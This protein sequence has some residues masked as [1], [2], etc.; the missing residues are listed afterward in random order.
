M[1]RNFKVGL[2][3]EPRIVVVVAAGSVGGSYSV[4]YDVGL[5]CTAERHDE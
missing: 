5:Q 1:A 3:Q 4:E 2:L